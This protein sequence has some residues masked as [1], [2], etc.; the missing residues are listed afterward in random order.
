VGLKLFLYT[1]AATLTGAAAGALLGA[2]GTVLQLDARVVIATV[3][4]PVAIVAG[5]VEV[6]GWRFRP[7]Q[8]DRET[9]Q[10]W[11]H[12]GPVRW[13]IVNGAALGFGASSRLGFWLWYVVPLG[14]LLL[15]DPL[16]G[17]LVYGAYG[18]ARALGAA[19]ILLAWR[20]TGDADPV[21]DWL[22]E[23][24]PFARRVAAAQLALLGLAVAVGVGL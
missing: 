9:P 3:L 18:L 20:I 12:L 6:G 7:L 19:G 21:A 24:S 11:V 13:S 22:L 15:A 23:R 8:C 4:A 10:R 14:S 1:A 16:V 2:L 17:A 5:A